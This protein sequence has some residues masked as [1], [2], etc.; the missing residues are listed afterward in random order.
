M[1]V[2]ASSLKHEYHGT[3]K[4]ADNFNPSEDAEALKNAMKGFGEKLKL[5]LLVKI[6]LSQH[7]NLLHLCRITMKLIRKMLN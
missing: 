6:L 3:L 2:P 4:P 7:I 1:W 5:T